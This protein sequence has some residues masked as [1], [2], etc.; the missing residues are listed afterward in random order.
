M[1]RID[2][3]FLDLRLLNED[4]LLEAASL[5][6][7]HQKYY[8]QIPEEEFRQ[9][10]AADPT[11]KED[12]MGKY[13]KWLLALYT[14]GNLKFEDLY[15]ATEYLTTFHRYKQKLERKDIGQYKSLPDLYD[16]I[17]PYE[18]NT[19]AASHKEEL[20]QIKKDAKKVY[21]DGEW[22]VIVPE[23][24][25]A[26]VEYGKGTQWC[27]A[28][29]G[30][31]N[32]FNYYNEK[33]PLYININK[34][35][36]AKYQFHFETNQ[37][38]DER[39]ESVSIS[40]ILNDNDGIKNFY[41]K[42]YGLKA[43]YDYVIEIHPKTEPSIPLY[44]VWHKEKYNLIDK[45]NDIKCDTW[46]DYMGRFRYD[47]SD[48]GKMDIT[49]VTLQYATNFIDLNGNLLF[50]EW[51]N[52]VG[53]FSLGPCLV[54]NRENNKYNYVTKDGRY[55]SPNIWF[56]DALEFYNGWA[57]VSTKLGTNLINEDGKF[58]SNEWYSLIGQFDRFINGAVVRKNGEPNLWNIVR[59]DGSLLSDEWFSDIEDP[60]LTFDN[61]KLAVVRTLK[62]KSNVN[63]I[64]LENGQK[65]FE[66]DCVDIC[67]VLNNSYIIIEK[68]I[69]NKIQSN[70]IRSDTK[71]LLL[72]T[73]VDF[74]EPRNVYFIEIHNN[75]KINIFSFEKNDYITD[76]WFDKI[77]FLNT[78]LRLDSFLSSFGVIARVYNDRKTNLL[79]SNGE[80][81]FR[82]WVDTIVAH[83]N[84]A[85]N[86]ITVKKDG[87]YNDINLSTGKYIN[88]KWSDEYWDY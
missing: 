36:G 12:K 87:K 29:T 61:E 73:W 39:D 56:N 53:D 88:D 33:G 63:L 80:L 84:F 52:Y 64:N 2:S 67:P 24:Q 10:V 17:Q 65:L 32:Y 83:C 9:I 74:I 55:L 34:K 54:C 77:Y 43:L 62:N 57:R 22:L 8:N 37:F 69:E 26:A 38:M 35:T 66:E 48:D 85:R 31:Y 75:G 21:E 6:D 11:A 28:A 71:Q 60:F 70:I 3:S 25:E 1:E 47:S 50:D 45:N 72:P 19:Q 76:E 46:Y 18:D 30:S 23:T 58:I 81:L 79:K 15:K 86:S 27:T 44:V 20:R 5:A 16:A 41:Y 49:M 82:E 68:L 4:L 13:S 7:V 78:R 51:F 42:K 59:L 14:S 40:E